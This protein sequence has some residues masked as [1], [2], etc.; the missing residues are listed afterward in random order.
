MSPRFQDRGEEDL[1]DQFQTADKKIRRKTR[2]LL[3]RLKNSITVSYENIILLAIGFIMSCVIFFSL[4]VERGRNDIGHVRQEPIQ[5]R[6]IEEKPQVEKAI[7]DKEVV[8]KKRDAGKYAIQLASFKKIEAA[9]RELGILKKE[10]YNADIKKSGDYYQLYIGGF[11]EKKE[12]E[13]I[14]KELKKRYTDSYI[15][16]LQ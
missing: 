9:E 3:P 11:G 2:L 4:G 14:L 6:R 15:K 5:V 1:F 8:Q 16:N 12:V 10:G 7:V 13:K